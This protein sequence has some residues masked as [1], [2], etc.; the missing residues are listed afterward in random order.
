MIKR[1]SGVFR[2]RRGRGNVAS[3]FEKIIFIFT[4][5]EKENFERHGQID[6]P[7][8]EYE[9]QARLGTVSA[10]R[11]SFANRRRTKFTTLRLTA[12]A[13]KRVRRASGLRRM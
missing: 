12:D 6:L 1:K 8:G 2:L 11:V 5:L 7:F 9:L 4:Q 10:R 13:F 3:V